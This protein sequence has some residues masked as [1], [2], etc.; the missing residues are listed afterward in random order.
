M[1]AAIHS[2]YGSPEG[3]QIIDTE[4]HCQSPRKFGE[5]RSTFS[6]YSPMDLI[7]NKNH[8]SKQSKNEQ[9]NTYKN[10]KTTNHWLNILY[11]QC[12]CTE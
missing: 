9:L 11:T 5:Y 4:N 3:V 6:N 10:E 1:K 2:K 7:K 12:F 8:Q